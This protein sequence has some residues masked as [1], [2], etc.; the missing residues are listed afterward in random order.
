MKFAILGAGRIA[1]VHARTFAS[2]PEH[3][4]EVV[5]DPFGDAAEKLAA[6]Y[7]ARAMKD[8]LEAIKDPEVDAVLVCTPTATIVNSRHCSYGYDQRFEVFGSEGMLY[9]NNVRPTTVESFNAEYTK[10][11][12]PVLDFFLERYADAYAEE[13]KAFV[14]SVV[15]G[16]APSPSVEAGREALKLAIAAEESARTGKT[17]KL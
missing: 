16:S 10:K 7:G 12:D 5:A 11:S 8:T 9:A 14:N 3:A 4:I 15:E 6:E 2:L 1:Q 17:V 13:L